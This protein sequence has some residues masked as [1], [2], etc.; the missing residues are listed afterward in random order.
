MKL[1]A[2]AVLL[3]YHH[4]WIDKLNAFSTFVIA[5]FTIL[6][7]I[8]IVVQIRTSRDTERAWVIATPTENAPVLGFIPE[9]GSNLERHLVGCDKR[10][11]FSCSFKS[12]G[13]TPARL[14]E[15]AICYRKV[16]QLEDVPQEPDY[17]PRSPMNDLPLVKEDSIGFMAFL[18]P[19]AILL[20]ADM[21]AVTQQK[22]LLYAFGMVVYRDV[23]SRLH[24]TRFGYVYHFPQGGDSREKGFRREGLPLAYN[25]AT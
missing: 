7:F 16:S 19:N 17:G 12:T 5:A 24:E 14:V 3:E 4:D 21:I 23:Y 15:T 1:L 10:N 13:D 18:E 25:R 20:R 2:L 11:V 6:L 22:A 8:G 9:G